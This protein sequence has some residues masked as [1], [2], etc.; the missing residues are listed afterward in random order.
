V[1]LIAEL[2]RL[3]F[4]EKVNISKLARRF[5]LSRPTVRKHLQTEGDP[6]YPTRKKQ[7]YPQLGP[8]L[9]R[10]G[11]WLEFDPG[12]RT[13]PEFSTRFSCLTAVSWFNDP[14]QRV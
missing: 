3:H 5:H 12:T 6:V 9:D 2:R 7:P 11:A 10:L 1:E 4:V 8:Y 14:V 13:L